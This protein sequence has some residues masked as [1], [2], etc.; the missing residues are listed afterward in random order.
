MSWNASYQLTARDLEAG[1]RLN[2]IPNAALD[3]QQ[4]RDLIGALSDAAVKRVGPVLD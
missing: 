3:D 4:R 2:I 1:Y